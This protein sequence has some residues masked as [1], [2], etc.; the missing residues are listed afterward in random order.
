MTNQ[1]YQTASSHYLNQFKPRFIKSLGH[2]TSIKTPLK[3]PFDIAHMPLSSQPR[4]T[5][6]WMTWAGVRLAEGIY[7]LYAN[8]DW[9][10][11]PEIEYDINATK[12]LHFK[13]VFFST[14]QYQGTVQYQ[15]LKYFKIR[16]LNNWHFRWN[17]AC[18]ETC[19]AWTKDI[20]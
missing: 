19:S 20:H 1:H 13:R 10:F 8:L 4:Q 9:I 16:F 11:A 3:I 7:S 12:Y 14:K 18:I 15:A 2:T 17:Y 5:D 6:P